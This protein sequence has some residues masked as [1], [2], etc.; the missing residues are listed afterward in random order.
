M[1]KPR[2]KGYERPVRGR[3]K[4]GRKDSAH[5]AF[6]RRLPCLITKTPDQSVAHHLLMKQHRGAGM[7]APDWYTV[8][9]RSDI[10]D[11]LHRDVP[12]RVTEDEWFWEREIPR[13]DLLALT[14]WGVHDN[15]EVAEMLVRMW[16][17]HDGLC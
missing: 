2:F 12:S 5:L 14:L 7:K 11:L 10:H 9:L 6:V 15:Y 16:R 4:E 13:P 17:N 1:V 3:A 8:P